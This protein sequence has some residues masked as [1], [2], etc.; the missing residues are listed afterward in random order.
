MHNGH[1]GP[2]KSARLEIKSWMLARFSVPIPAASQEPTSGPR[3]RE[4]LAAKSALN[5]R[6]LLWRYAT[7]VLDRDGGG[8]DIPAIYYQFQG[9]L[10]SIF[11]KVACRER[12]GFAGDEGQI[13]VLPQHRQNFF[14]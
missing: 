11:A 14:C 13:V 12:P 8:F 4:G 2:V 3:L 10:E 5:A 7:L 9:F 6:S 1:T